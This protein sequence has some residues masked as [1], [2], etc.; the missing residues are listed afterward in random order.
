MQAPWRALQAR[1]SFSFPAGRAGASA[2]WAM[3]CLGVVLRVVQYLHN[4]SLWLDEASIALNIAERDFAELLRPLAYKQAAPVGF[5]WACKASVQALG[6]SEFALRVWPL[7]CGLLAL[8]LLAKVGRKVVGNFGAFAVLA[9][10]ALSPKLIYYASEVKQYSTDMA[11]AAALLWAIIHY[12][13][14]RTGWR[15]ALLG[16]VSVV[17]VLCSHP[18]VFGV[19]AAGVHVLVGASM[20]LPAHRARAWRHVA[21]F[22]SVVLAA[23]AGVY[24]LNVR[25]L[26]G[27]SFQHG[28]WAGAGAFPPWPS[29][30]GKA[31]WLPRQLHAFVADQLALPG[32]AVLGLA[33]LG[34][35][36]HKPLQPWRVALLLPLGLALLA[37]VLRQY[38]FQ[39]RLLYFCVPALLVLAAGGLAELR[40]RMGKGVAWAALGSCLLLPTGDALGVLR[41]PITNS[42]LRPV[43]AAVQRWEQAGHSPPPIYLYYNATRVYRYYARWQGLRLLGHVVEGAWHRGAPEGYVQDIHQALPRG[44]L[45]MFANDRTYG[46]LSEMAYITQRLKAV[47]LMICADASVWRFAADS[48]GGLKH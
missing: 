3:L 5:L 37:A 17:G 13:Q 32:M 33:V 44:G 8:A 26:M 35:W 45:L 28:F 27:H 29:S 46:G 48:S 2:V 4:R 10:F 20:A 39:G 21:I 30:L 42:E 19:A 9:L 14:R 16:S 15:L 12:G 36:Q 23:L 47:P 38:P 40:L 22:A 34:A 43:L 24:V 11:V 41:H 6:P 25:A 31:L 18:G 7:C 1:L